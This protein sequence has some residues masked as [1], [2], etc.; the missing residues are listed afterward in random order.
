MRIC[1]YNM[2][3]QIGLLGLMYYY[4]SVIFRKMNAV[5]YSYRLAVILPVISIILTY[6]AYRGIRKDDILIRS[7]DKI[8]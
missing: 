3:L 1:V 8:R 2:L 6:L 7:M 5:E 4:M